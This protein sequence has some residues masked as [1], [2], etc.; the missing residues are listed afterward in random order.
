MWWKKKKRVNFLY[1]QLMLS[2]FTVTKDTKITLKVGC[3]FSDN[4]IRISDTIANLGEMY[5]M[6][7]DNMDISRTDFKIG[8]DGNITVVLCSVDDY[9]TF[10]L[11]KTNAYKAYLESKVKK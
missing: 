9:L 4:D 11:K 1:A 3:S 10:E 8:K 7:Y 5:N 6:L 2:D